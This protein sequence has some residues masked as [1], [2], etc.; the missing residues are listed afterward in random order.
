MLQWL[1]NCSFGDT[2]IILYGHQL[3][4][5]KSVYIYDISKYSPCLIYYIYIVKC[6]VFWCSYVQLGSISTAFI[7]YMILLTCFLQATLVVMPLIV[8]HF[9]CC[10]SSF[11][12]VQSFG[13]WLS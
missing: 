12:A 7:L 5:V 3:H 6:D 13:F 10:S 2:C 8:I 11:D 4:E 9:S 1:L